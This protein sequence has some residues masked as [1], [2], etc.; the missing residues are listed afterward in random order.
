M[1][2][3]DL[4]YLGNGAH[5]NYDDVSQNMSENYT[6]A[7]NQIQ[8]ETAR[9]AKG[10]ET[11]KQSKKSLFNNFYAFS[12]DSSNVFVDEDLQ[13]NNKFKNP[14]VTNLV[15]NKKGAN[16]FDYSDFAYASKLG[17][18]PNNRLI[19]LRR[20][21]YPVGDDIFG[22]RHEPDLGRLVSWFTQNE[23]KL[24]SIFGMSYGM[25]WKPLT[26][27][28]EQ[29][30][31]SSPGIGYSGVIGSILEKY[32]SP[33]TNKDDYYDPHHDHN[34]VYGPV[35]S[36]TTTHIRDVGLNF[37]QN[38]VITFNYELRS[39]DGVNPKTAFI[40]L[41][42][43]ILAVTMNDGKFWGG[44]RYW[45]GRPPSEYASRIRH[46]TQDNFA[47][48]VQSSNVNIKS[49]LGS[50]ASQIQQTL[51][52]ENVIDLASKVLKNMAISK[53]L[54]IAGR[55]S[56]PLMN[57]LL[58][59]DPVGEWHITVGNPLRPI[60]VAGNLILKDTKIDIANDT[61]GYDD[62]P[63]EL[64]VTCTL[65][66]AMPRA[67]AEI[68][69]MFT[70]GNGRNYWKPSKQDFEKITR[71]GKFV[72]ES[73]QSHSAADIA[74]V[75]RE[76]YSYAQ[77]QLY[78]FSNSLQPLNAGTQTQAPSNPQSTNSTLKPKT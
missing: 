12:G 73:M 43:H 32:M 71:T 35:D 69:Q 59:N 63:T 30:Q 9:K 16:R 77:T 26:A 42:S 37:A 7:E 61:L 17:E 65:E 27:A 36:I 52:P 38:I 60:F 19:T 46:W 21:K 29:M 55:A 4:Q 58:T 56:V 62:F 22:S 13:S 74:I 3:D 39:I 66:H 51:T 53:A 41:L 1:A 54:D 68:E 47:S 23:N 8:A 14:S 70:I 75:G 49:M 45:E 48:F 44:A 24:T 57:S 76:L 6:N 78:G 28:F 72:K 11:F 5:I 15:G 33:N 2:I 18:V 64:V 25:N 31:Q 50:L 67:R 40:D 20:F 34:K 10:S